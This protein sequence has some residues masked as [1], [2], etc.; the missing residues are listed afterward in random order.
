M[1]L[2]TLEF[3]TGDEWRTVNSIKDTGNRGRAIFSNNS[4]SGIFDFVNISNLG[5]ARNFGNLSNDRA[6]AF[7]CAS[8]TRGLWAG[9]QNPARQDVIDYMTIASEGDA[10]DFGNLIEA[11]SEPCATSSST[12][13]IWCGDIKIPVE[14]LTEQM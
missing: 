3:Y 13:G 11:N 4:N 12:R 5:N 1:V 6:S 14:V 2:G 9:G 7:G 8:S 10:I